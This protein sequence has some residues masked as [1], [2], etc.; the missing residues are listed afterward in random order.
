MRQCTSNMRETNRLCPREKVE[1][2]RLQAFASCRDVMRIGP[3]CVGKVSC[4]T[5]PEV[6]K[7]GKAQ[8]RHLGFP[9]DTHPWSSAVVAFRP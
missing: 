2:P 9:R 7:L 6:C 5:T 4:Q 3:H 1:A 8:K